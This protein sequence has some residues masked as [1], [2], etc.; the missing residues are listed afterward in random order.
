MASTAHFSG[1]GLTLKKSNQP[2]CFN[3][4]IYHGKNQ[5]SLLLNKVLYEY[6]TRCAYITVGYIFN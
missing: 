1:D 6:D 3:F 5:W 4:A 2:N